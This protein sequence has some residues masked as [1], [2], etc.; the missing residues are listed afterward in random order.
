MSF[1]LFELFRVLIEFFFKNDPRFPLEATNSMPN[2]PISILVCFSFFSLSLSL[3]LS[4]S[5][6]II[7]HH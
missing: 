4:P 3:S 5:I 2:D 1:E 7:Y 6:I